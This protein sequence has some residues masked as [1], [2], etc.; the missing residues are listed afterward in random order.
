MSTPYIMPMA[1]GP[2]QFVRLPC[3]RKQGGTEVH[4]AATEQLL[5]CYQVEAQQAEI[6]EIQPMVGLRDLESQQMLW[7]SSEVEAVLKIDAGMGL[8]LEPDGSLNHLVGGTQGPVFVGPK[9]ISDDVVTNAKGEIFLY[10]DD[11]STFEETFRAIDKFGTRITG[12]V[13]PDSVKNMAIEY[14]DEIRRRHTAVSKHSWDLIVSDRMMGALPS[15]KYSGGI[16]KVGRYSPWVVKKHLNWVSK[17]HGG[18]LDVVLK[19]AAMQHELAALLGVEVF[20]ANF[21]L[22]TKRFLPAEFWVEVE[23][24]WCDTEES[25]YKVE[26]AVRKVIALEEEAE[27]PRIL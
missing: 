13:L 9:G 26:A 5:Q 24:P 23:V 22:T 7:D 25:M 6:P 10:S 27:G 18:I 2:Y 3:F 19:I 4:F 21:L 20:S 1:K 15:S 8:I 14:S 17:S 11:S 12:V 16:F